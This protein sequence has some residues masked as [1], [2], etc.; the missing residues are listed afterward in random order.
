MMDSKP[1]QP[2]KDFIFPKRSFGKSVVREY[3]FQAKWFDTWKWL[4]WDNCK[5]AVL[6]HVCA[7]AV[8]SGKL[9]F[10]KNAEA[11]FVNRG[12][13]NWKDATRLFRAHELSKCHI[14]AV[15]K[16]VHLPA[17]T[18]DIGEMLVGQ[19]ADDKKRNREM[20]LY[21]FRSV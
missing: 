9:T 14:E 10:S 20:L 1:Y 16:M 8:E 13:Q 6:C 17:T 21:V 12:F 18:P 5:Q 15:E 4:H 7:K 3:S 2:G 19:L 11:S